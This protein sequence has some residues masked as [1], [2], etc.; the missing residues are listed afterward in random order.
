MKTPI[1]HLESAADFMRGMRF[2]PRIP[3][4]VKAALDG[5]IDA[6]DEF[7][8]SNGWISVT[9]QLPED[10]DHIIMLNE[11]GER[12]SGRGKV[13]KANLNQPEPTHGKTTRY[14]HWQLM[15]EAPL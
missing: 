9:V 4:D 1:Q 14:T 2:D 3:S 13:L 8:E 6:I 5:R 12:F 15:T 7:T 10:T 11:S